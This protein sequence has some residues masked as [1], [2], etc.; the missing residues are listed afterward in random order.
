ML[1]LAILMKENKEKLALL[2]TLDTE[3]TY[4]NYYQTSIPKAIEALIY[5]VESIDKIYGKAIPPQND[6]MAL[7]T[8][9]ALRVL[10]IIIS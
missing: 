2:D 8:R 10:E 7:V 4:K 1:K 6:F 9:E 3:R 5:F